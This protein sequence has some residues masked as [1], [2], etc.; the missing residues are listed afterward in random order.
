MNKLKN[1]YLILYVIVYISMICFNLLIG[2]AV[3]TIFLSN[4]LFLLN[5][6]TKT[7]Y[8]LIFMFLIWFSVRTGVINIYKLKYHYNNSEEKIN[9]S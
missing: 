1:W 2:I 4:D 3:V 7:D 5:K 8:L 6:A 9:D